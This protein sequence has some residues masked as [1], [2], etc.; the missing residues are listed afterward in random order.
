MLPT[1]AIAACLRETRCSQGQQASLVAFSRR[2]GQ[3]LRS[4]SHCVHSREQ[5]QQFVSGSFWYRFLVAFSVTFFLQFSSHHKERQE[6][7]ED[8]L[9]LNVYTPRETS[10]TTSQLPC[11]WAGE[12]G[13]EPFKCD[14]KQ[15]GSQRSQ[16]PNGNSSD[17][18]LLLFFS[19]L[20]PSLLLN[21][22]FQVSPSEA[23]IMIPRDLYLHL[24]CVEATEIHQEQMM[25]LHLGMPIKWP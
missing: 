13:R 15:P 5:S 3:W 8:C 24:G 7:R 21:R 4:T 19:T 6:S 9:F 23:G 17:P 25:Y 22:D 12:L 18:T 10:E 11:H 16:Q 1:M 2:T 20:L 14:R